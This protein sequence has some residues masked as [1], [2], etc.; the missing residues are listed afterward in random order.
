MLNGKQSLVAI[1][2][3]KE[4]KKNIIFK[5]TFVVYWNTIGRTERA[6]TAK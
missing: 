5:A 4:R 2:K 1:K 3:K 6:V